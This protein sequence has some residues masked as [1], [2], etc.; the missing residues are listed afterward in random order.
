MNILFSPLGMTDP[1]Q[2]FHDGAML[3]ICR[4]YEI[5]KV[6]L[7]MSK[8]VC[9]NHDHDNR[10]LYCLDMLGQTLGRKIEHELIKKEDLTEVH[11]FDDMINEYRNIVE[12]IHSDYPEATLYPNVSSGTPAMKSAL[13]VVAS[14]CDF[15]LTPIQVATPER[16][17]NP[18]VEE[19]LNYDTKGQWECNEDN[20]LSK[21]RCEEAHNTNFVTE[22]KKQIVAGLIKDYDYAGAY[23]ATKNM[24]EAIGKSNVEL[25]RAAVDRSNLEYKKA[26]SVFRQNGYTLLAADDNDRL[27]IEY[28]LR[29]YIRVKRREYA[30]FLRSITP[31][32]SNLFEKILKDR[33]G[34]V[35]D[36]YRICEVVKTNAKNTGD[37]KGYRWDA[38][39]L[40]QNAPHVYQLL[41]ARYSYKG[42]LKL[43][44]I[45]TDNLACVISG[46]EQ[47]DTIK[48]TVE[49][50]RN[51]ERNNRNLA[52]H[53]MCY[54]NE[55]WIKNRNNISCDAF[56]KLIIKAFSYTKIKL[57][58]GF[59]DSYEEM[60]EF[61]VGQM[62]VTM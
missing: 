43:G 28:F 17:S 24:E 9:E 27:L 7:Y 62:N 21:N 58:S 25:I 46:L 22:V 60:N 33:C 2:N 51:F 39:K 45:E 20:N 53:E 47:D 12:R 54:I 19:K 16:A 32:V 50:I 23:E 56:I 4:Y 48:T 41:S 10:Y 6:Y 15:K 5:D 26:D 34:F 59:T 40:S 35:V 3:H 31:L 44:N 57:P 14:F 30:D 55:E 18:R 42:P 37:L 29:V 1:I 8:E 11:V 52:A 61:L 13:W 38:A 36:D 49:N